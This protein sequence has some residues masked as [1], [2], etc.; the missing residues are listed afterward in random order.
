MYA[1]HC[2]FVIWCILLLAGRV[3]AVPAGSSIAPPPPL[4]PVQFLAP[5]Q[6]SKRPWIRLRD[7]IIEKIWGISKNRPAHS[8]PVKDGLRSRLPPAKVL[9]RYGSDVVLRF[10]LREPEEV[11]ALADAVNVLFLDV[12]DSTDAYVDIR[13]AQE[14]I[15]SLLGLL[16]RSLQ[17]SHT[18]LIDDLSELIYASYPSHRSADLDQ[19]PLFSPS[20]RQKSNVADLFFDDYQP[21]SVIIP[22]MRLM[23]S[24]FSP[25]VQM[26]NVGMTY[27]GRDIP[28]FRL[29]VRRPSPE[30]PLEPRK[31]VL[32]IGGAHAREWISTS[33]VAYI[34]YRLITGYGKS[35][36]ITRLLEDFDWVLVPTINPDGYVYSWEMD[37]LWR[38]N[39]QQTG[40]HFCPGIDLDRS[41][42]YAWD[43]EGTRANPC[44]ESYAG[45]QAFDSVETRT[46]AE[47]A[48][49]ETLNNVDIIGFLDL[50]SYSQQ[51][52]YPYSYSCASVPPTLEN[53]EE[54]AMGLAKAIRMT[55]RETYKVSPACEGVVVSDQRD[56]KRRILPKVESSGGSALDWFYN[57][58]HA[59]YS[60]QIKLRDKGTY[61]FL[62]P[63]EEIV[64]TGKELFNSILVFGHFLLAE[65]ANDV[66]W[67]LDLPD[68]ASGVAS[69]IFNRT[70]FRSDQQSVQYEDNEEDA[71]MNE[72]DLDEEYGWE[73]RRRK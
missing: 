42:G 71:Q 14:V 22:W 65:R 32:I 5:T 21:L 54:L 47:W 70:L 56:G 52:L 16:P 38:K 73:L 23:A 60:Y 41:W 39:R 62:L 3:P 25:H 13:L 7:S 55:N 64:P 4:E 31:T 49:N 8:C 10:E 53:L 61:G 48:L 11:Q 51:I 28:A 57:Q 26:I 68:A 9:T 59:K 15:P 35:A 29:G 34:A 63:P 2:V 45:D 20:L 30:P 50:H 58:L 67:E 43:G 33:T 46:I 69:G 44:S 1:L 24:M 66:E 36:S 27:E 19:G 6:K 40:L 12:W 37:R 18:L 17:N 72:D